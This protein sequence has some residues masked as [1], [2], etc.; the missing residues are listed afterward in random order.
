MVLVDTSAWFEYLRDTR[1][2]A[3]VQVE[4]LLSADLTMCGVVLMDLLAGARNE[5]PDA[6]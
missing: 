5:H 3:C 4:A 1:S 6:N 2:P